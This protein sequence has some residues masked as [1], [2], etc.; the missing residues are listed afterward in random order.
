MQ[1]TAGILIYFA[2]SCF[3]G[4][5]TA[6]TFALE[7]PYVV[8]RKQIDVEFSLQRGMRKIEISDASPGPKFPSVSQ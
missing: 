4:F 1:R 7:L 6:L 2:K 5:L 3:L 8:E